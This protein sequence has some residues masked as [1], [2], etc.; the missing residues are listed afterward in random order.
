MNYLAHAYLSQE[1]DAAL[2]GA[3]LGDFVKGA[4]DDRYPPAV[5]DA[6]RLHRSIDCYT[7]GHALVRASRAL[8]SRER[9]RFA[10]ILVDVFYDHFLAL[11]WGRFSATPLEAFTARVYAALQPSCTSY[12]PRLQRLL[13]H[14]TRE[15]WLASYGEI[16][17]VDAALNGIALRFKRFERA[18]V[19]GDAVEELSAN[20]AAF[21]AHF[22]AFFPQLAR[23]AQLTKQ[24]AAA[25]AP[26]ARARVAF[27]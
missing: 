25:A 27:G 5:R 8:V 21:E 10:G 23:H 7:D 20:Y 12:P 19:L 17:A 4:L 2:V 13:P 22:L 3:L 6:I 14:M 26:A 15:D 24:H 9:R 18:R 1:S 16:E 11:H